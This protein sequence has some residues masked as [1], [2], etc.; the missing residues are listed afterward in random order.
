MDYKQARKERE[1]EGRQVANALLGMV[2]A[3]DDGPGKAFIDELSKG[4][5]TLQQEVTRLFV[6]WIKKLAEM[7]SSGWYDLRNESSVKLARK[8]LDEIPEEDLYLP[9]I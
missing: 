8:I 2:N 6:A 9:F 5:R 1:E 4:H 3:Y 7:E